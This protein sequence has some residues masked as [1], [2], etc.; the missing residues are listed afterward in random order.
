[1]I[2]KKNTYS[3]EEISNGIS[4]TGI[5]NVP[6][7]TRKHTLLAD[8]PSCQNITAGFVN[9]IQGSYNKDKS[10][11]ETGRYI[12]KIVELKTR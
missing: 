3:V 9:G 12:N 5:V 6:H 2:S 11:L 4:V 1:M 8:P 10:K 7:S